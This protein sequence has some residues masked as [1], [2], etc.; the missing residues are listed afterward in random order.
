M[1]F[2]DIEDNEWDYGFDIVRGSIDVYVL[3]YY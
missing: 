2:V 3:C 1:V